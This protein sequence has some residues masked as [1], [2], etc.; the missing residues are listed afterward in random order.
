MGS[1]EARTTH[2]HRVG[3][4]GPSLAGKLPREIAG[5]SR[6]TRVPFAG[7]K[8]FIE[9]PHGRRWTRKK[10]DGLRVRDHGRFAMLICTMPHAP[11]TLQQLA[12]WK[13]AARGMRYEHM[14]SG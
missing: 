4:V 11:A 3:G 9:A 13:A 1:K 8:R 10:R 14:A 7:N 6:L 12:A 2:A 5:D